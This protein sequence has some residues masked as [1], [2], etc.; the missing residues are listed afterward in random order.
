MLFLKQEPKIRERRASLR[1][2]AWPRKRDLN[3]S[4]KAA[5]VTV[6]PPL[7]ESG[8]RNDL[9]SLITAATVGQM[10]RGERTLQSRWWC[11][12]NQV[13]EGRVLLVV[14][15]VQPESREERCWWLVEVKGR[16]L[17][18]D[19]S[20]GGAEDQREW[21]WS[22]IKWKKKG[23]SYREEQR[24]SQ[25]RKDFCVL[26]KEVGRWQFAEMEGKNCFSNGQQLPNK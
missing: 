12:V 15:F 23:G 2:E 4:S 10:Q 19:G 11:R 25:T 26:K 17:M 21:W 5:A 24:L 6:S 18:V 3:G 16:K 22:R 20:D 13:A 7:P 8:H 14:L 1:L 9:Q